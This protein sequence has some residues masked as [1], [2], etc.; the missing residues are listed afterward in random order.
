M[1]DGALLE[2]EGVHLPGQIV[3]LKAIVPLEVTSPPNFSGRLMVT[4]PRRGRM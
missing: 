1:L 4:L 3:R 2:V